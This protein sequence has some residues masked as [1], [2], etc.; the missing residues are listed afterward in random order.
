MPSARLHSLSRCPFALLPA[1]ILNLSLA[2]SGVAQST[3]QR[4]GTVEL[5]SM[6]GAYVPTAQ[7]SSLVPPPALQWEGGTQ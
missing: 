3:T 6:V 2:P 5:S 1:V 7:L 4:A